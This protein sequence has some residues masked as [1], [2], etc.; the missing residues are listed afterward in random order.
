MHTVFNPVQ[1]SVGKNSL[2]SLPALL[3]NRKYVIVSSNGYFARGWDRLA[4]TPEFIIDSVRANPTVRDIGTFLELLNNHSC[5]TLVAI[6]GGSVIDVAK[7]MSVLSETS[8]EKIIETIEGNAAKLSKQFEVIAI[9]TTGGT[10][11]EV[12][13]FATIWDDRR[14]K[15][16]SLASGL[17][18]PE[19]GI[20]DPSMSVSLDIKMTVTSGLDALSHCLESI[21][22]HNA[23]FYTRSL[24]FNAVN[25]FFN[26][27]LPLLDDLNNIDLRLNMAW[28]SLIGGMCI[29]NTKTALAHSMSYPLTSHL[30][31]PHGLAAG[32]FLPEILR[33]NTLNDTTGYMDTI[34]DTMSFPSPLQ[35]RLDD[36]F[37]QLHMRDAFHEF[38]RNLEELY[39]LVPEMINPARS[40]NNIVPTNT[41]DVLSILDAFFGKDQ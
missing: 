11:S 2:H 7:S 14:H 24:A 36:L 29:S 9:P 19:Y 27:L 25:V 20:V 16:L 17:L 31:I 41:N 6:G 3:K 8:E 35:E 4:P 37:T 23:T 34:L 30:N 13:P 33:Y 32:A 18:Y 28:I 38:T 22:N 5:D 21:W 1:I 10:G 12:T 39:S 26:T 15:K 40:A